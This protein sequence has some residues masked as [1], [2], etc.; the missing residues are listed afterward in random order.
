MIGWIKATEELPVIKEMNSRVE[1]PIYVM[2][3]N[4]VMT[5]ADFTK[6]KF[7]NGDEWVGD[8]EPI[9]ICRQRGIDISGMEV[10]VKYWQRQPKPM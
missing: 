10:N 7:K 8:Y 6:S 2:L 3:D 4:G 9:W 1:L 5:I